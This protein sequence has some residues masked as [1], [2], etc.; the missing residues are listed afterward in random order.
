VKNVE[1]QI[2]ISGVSQ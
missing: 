2:Y 1:V